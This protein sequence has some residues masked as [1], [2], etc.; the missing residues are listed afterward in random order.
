MG[1]TRNIKDL[2]K[3][4]NIYENGLLLQT[5]GHTLRPGGFL[6]T[7][8]AVRNCGFLPGA[9]V[10]DVGCGYGAT[11]DRLVSLYQLK[12]FGIDPSEKLLNIGHQNYPHLSLSQG[13]GEK[14]PFAD[15][16]M[17]G[18]FAECSLSLMTDTNQALR[19]MYRVLKSAGRLVIH[20]VYARN[21]Q[22]VQELGE[23]SL[24]SCIRHALTEEQILES[25]E[26]HGFQVLQW[27]DHSQLLVQLAVELIMKHGS[28]NE[29]WLKSAGFA[30]DQEKVQ[31]ALKKA[32]MGYFQ[33]IVQKS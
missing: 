29:F 10:L 33:V 17:D 8:Q 19:E 3:T 16:S 5:T 24:N 13:I 31:G 22:G 4:D 11:V 30:S 2:M 20:D 18:V 1:R 27:Q 26:S 23:L 9:E 12:A 15:R 21:A 7:D 6:L 28:M 14:L 32:R 25:L